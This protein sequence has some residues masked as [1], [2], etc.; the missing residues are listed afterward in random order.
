M[1]TSLGLN[2][3]LANYPIQHAQ[4]AR[5]SDVRMYT[6]WRARTTALASDR[7]TTLETLVTPA[8]HT[9]PRLLRPGATS[10]LRGT[11]L[12][13]TSTSIRTMVPVDPGSTPVPALKRTRWFSAL[14]TAPEP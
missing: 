1:C 4:E 10:T 6:L 11:T 2:R 14:Q 8:E 9:S 5:G 13:F 3:T 12:N 7:S